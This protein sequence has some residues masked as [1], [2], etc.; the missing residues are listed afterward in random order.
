MNVGYLW[1]PVILFVGGIIASANMFSTA[2]KLLD[3]E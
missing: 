2:L 1:I 3:K